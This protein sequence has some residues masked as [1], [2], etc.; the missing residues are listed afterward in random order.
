[1]SWTEMTDL[2]VGDLVS[3]ADMDAIRTNIEYL[4]NP[5]DDATLHNEGSD[6]STTS[7][8][9]VDVDATDLAATITTNGGPVLVIVTGAAA[10]NVGGWAY[11]D[12]DVD[13]TRHGSANTLGLMALYAN[14]SSDYQSITLCAWITG[15]GAD[16]HTFKLQWRAASGT[17]YLKSTTSTIPVGLVAVEL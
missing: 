2:G 5:D 7:G 9:F 13:G 1:M 15:L 16:S 11:F 17:A 3:A 12:I 8:S 14:S 4:L 6:Y 10:H